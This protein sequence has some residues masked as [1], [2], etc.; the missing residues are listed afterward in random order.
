MMCIEIHRKYQYTQCPCSLPSIQHRVFVQLER[1]L[2][3]TYILSK[4]RQFVF[5]LK[6]FV[7]SCFIISQ[8]TTYRIYNVYS[9]W[10]ISRHPIVRDFVNITTLWAG[11]EMF[12]WPQAYAALTHTGL[13]NEAHCEFVGCNRTKANK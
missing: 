12:S 4:F 13:N 6:M 9:S 5:E 3:K 8:F 11:N 2:Q 1:H 10:V 7:K